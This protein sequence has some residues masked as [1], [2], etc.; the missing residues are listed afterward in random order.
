[1]TAAVAETDRVRFAPGVLLRHDRARDAWMLLGPERVLMLDEIALEVV[2]ACVQAEVPVGIGIDTL[3]SAFA[4]PRAE[5]A[6]DVL[7]VLNTLRNRGFI[8]G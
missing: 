4:A 3:A 8:I 6:R 1:M 2:R 5:I 7:D